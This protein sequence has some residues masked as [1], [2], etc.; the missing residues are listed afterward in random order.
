MT[1]RKTMI[2]A[3]ATG[4]VALIVTPA[5]AAKPRK[6][7]V[8]D[9]Q[10]QASRAQPAHSAKAVYGWDGRYLGNDPDPN[11]RFQLMRDQNMPPD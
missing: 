7:N 9:T 3:A 5:L 11:I 8:S 10:A 6:T 1:W 2:I 4:V